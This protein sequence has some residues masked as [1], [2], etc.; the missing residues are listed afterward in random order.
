M[1]A[2]IA[3]L[4]DRFGAGAVIHEDAN[5]RITLVDALAHVEA[6]RARRPG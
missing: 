2:R 6:T 4:I 5:R 1:L 3:R